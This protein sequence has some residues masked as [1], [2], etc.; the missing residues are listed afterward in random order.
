MGITLPPSLFART[1]ILYESVSAILQGRFHI[2]PTV[3]SPTR[4]INNMQRLQ[5]LPIDKEQ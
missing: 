4:T 5:Q 1:D 2:G 3:Y